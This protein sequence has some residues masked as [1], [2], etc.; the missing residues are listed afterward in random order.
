MRDES[1]ATRKSPD[2][3]LWKIVAASWLVLGA[4]AI[5]YV[6]GFRHGHR[7]AWDHAEYCATP[8]L[9]LAQR[10]PTRSPATTMTHSTPLAN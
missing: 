6:R 5:G 8:V 9:Q 10:P 1:G 4:L 2:R 7:Y 3:S